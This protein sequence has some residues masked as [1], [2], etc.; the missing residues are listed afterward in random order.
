MSAFNKITQ[1]V[2]SISQK[3]IEFISGGVKRIFSPTD[4]D[5]PNT[6]VQPYEGDPPTNRDQLGGLNFVEGIKFLP[7]F[8]EPLQGS[9]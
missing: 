1:S 2:G 9:F 7:C 3:I 6:G 5:Y 4:D 8:I